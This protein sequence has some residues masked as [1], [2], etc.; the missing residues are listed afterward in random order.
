[1]QDEYLTTA[2]H[3]AAAKMEEVEKETAITPGSDQGDFGEQFSDFTW[4][5]RIEDS[6]IQGLEIVIVTVKWDTGQGEDHVELTSAL[7]RTD[8][9][10]S[11]GTAP[12]AGGGTP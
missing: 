12:A 11:S 3:L 1:V 2:T 8:T 5:V 9:Q 7:P 6:P 10:A 4:T